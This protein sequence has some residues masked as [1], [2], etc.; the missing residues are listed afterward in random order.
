M[1][2]LT[3]IADELERIADSLEVI[4]GKLTTEGGIDLTDVLDRTL[5]NHN[6]YGLADGVHD[7]VTA[8][9]EAGQ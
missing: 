8:A 6:G 9:Y 1:S 7:L 3:R 4:E 5:Y 2:D